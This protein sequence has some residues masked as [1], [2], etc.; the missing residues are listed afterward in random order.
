MS[1]QPEA[2]VPYAVFEGDRARIRLAELGLRFEYFSDAVTRG[3]ELRQRCMPVHPRTYAG[4]VMWAETVAELRTQLLSLQESWEI[5]SSR[6]YETVFSG[7]RRIA[8]AVVGGNVYTGINDVIRPKSARSRGPVTSSRIAHNEGQ[9]ALELEGITVPV[10]SDEE[11]ITWLFLVNAR[12]NQLFSELS[13]ATSM[14]Q[15]GRLGRWVQRILLPP[16]PLSG[17]VTPIE[18]PE[19]DQPSSVHVERR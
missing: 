8:I 14:G 17:A 6:N 11:C 3:D 7:R 16:I 2:V 13:L 15:D 12:Q 10:E 1:V 18:P 9:Y 19:D 4:Q 5:G